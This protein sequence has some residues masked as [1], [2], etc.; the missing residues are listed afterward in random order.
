M[1]SRVKL[2]GHPV[3]QMLI[4]IPAGLFIVA[5][6][7]DV[8]DRFVDAAWIPTVTFWNLS[9]GVVSALLAAVFGLAD[10]TNIPSNTRAKRVGAMHGIGNVLAVAIF[11][12]AIYL[13]VDELNYY[14]SSAALTLEIIGFALLGVTAWLGGE[15]VD[16]L[17]VGVDPGAHV[18]APSSLRSKHVP[19]ARH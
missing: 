3:H 19:H 9:L 15:L 12:L 6:I 8:V 14:A 4:P 7:L 10:W 2:L 11:G 18:D 16:R 5:A 17:G 1:E 13:R